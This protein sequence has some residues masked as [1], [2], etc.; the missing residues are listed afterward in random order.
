VS[1]AVVGA[2]VAGVCFGLAAGGSL[3]YEMMPAREPRPCEI[4]RNLSDDYI[5]A[6]ADLLNDVS[7]RE[8]AVG[9]EDWQAHDDAVNANLRELRKIS[10]PYREAF[11]ECEDARP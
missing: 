4:A 3:V 2:A 10:A 6:Q 7:A 9:T 8:R 1:R 5:Y 11:H